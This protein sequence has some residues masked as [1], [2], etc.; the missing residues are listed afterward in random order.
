MNPF[1]KNPFINIGIAKP[2]KPVKQFDEKKRINNIKETMAKLKNNQFVQE[3]KQLNKEQDQ[4]FS[5]KETSINDK[6]N[7]LKDMDRL[8]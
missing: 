6:I 7:T 3:E 2:L 5:K 1:G 4:Q 8:K